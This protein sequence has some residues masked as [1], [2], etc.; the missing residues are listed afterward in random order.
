MTARSRGMLCPSFALSFHPLLT[1]GAGK[2]GCRLAP[3][4]RC[5]KACAQEHS[6]THRAAGTTR[7]SLRSGLTA[8]AVVAPVR[9]ALLPPSPCGLLM[10]LPGWEKHI[11]AGLGASFGRQD[12]T[13][14][15]YARCAVR[16]RA[17]DRSRAEGPPCNFRIAPT[18]GASTASRPASRDDSRSAP[19][20]GPGR[21]IYTPIPNSDKEK[22]FRRWAL[23]VSR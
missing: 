8:Y 4:V 22:Y 9:R 19:R 7:P 21:E 17:G 12:H 16:P 15:P 6:E 18:Q 20:V 10:R 11:T 2:A 23:T 14:L 3:M 13:V 5:A 1:E